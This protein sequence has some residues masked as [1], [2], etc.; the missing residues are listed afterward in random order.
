[1][2]KK[3]TI[4]D[5][6][7]QKKD[8]II[9]KMVAMICVVL[10]TVFLA[11]RVNEKLLW[12]LVYM[13]VFAMIGIFLTDLA[14]HRFLRMVLDY[15]NKIEK[16]SNELLY[17]ND[18]YLLLTEEYIFMGAN[19]Y[20]FSCTRY[21]DVKSVRREEFYTRTVRDAPKK[22]IEIIIKLKDGVEHS[23]IVYYEDWGNP[24]I[25]RDIVPLLLNK[26]PDIIVEDTIFTPWY[27]Q[28]KKL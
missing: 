20:N 28:R 11:V 9:Y 4:D 3:I 22:N 12:G 10:F 19:R 15:L 14:I 24:N 2:E 23:T 25:K 18:H 5:L 7:K 26:N 27:K 16:G 13:A 8:F 21:N 17:W 6:V 1:M